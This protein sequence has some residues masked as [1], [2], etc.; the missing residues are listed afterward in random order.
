MLY[1]NTGHA[2][3]RALQAHSEPPSPGAIWIDLLN[4]TDEERSAA[5][6]L[7]GLRVP[8]QTELAEVE[9]S[10]CLATE[11][12]T[13]Y[14]SMS[15]A[16]RSAEGVPMTAPLG[17]VLS[18]DHL[19]TV[20]SAVLPAFE[21]FAERFMGGPREPCS[22][23][24]FLGL[25]EATVDRLADVLELVGADLDAISRRVFRPEHGGMPKRAQMDLQLR[26]TL[27]GVGNAG[28]RVS[29]IRDSL[30][31]VNRIV[32]YTDEVAGGWVPEDLRPRFKTL[33]RD[34]A[35]LSD[36]DIQLTDK[37]QFL[38]DAT[39]GFINIEQNNGIKI[40]TVVSIVGVPPTLI[41][42]IYGMNFKNIPELQW[43]HGYAYG[44][45]AIAL[46]AILPL[47]WFK[48]RGWI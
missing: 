41:A 27:R 9:S 14:L 21:Q 22:V 16:Y 15:M 43:E 28:E 19:M 26:A 4:P 12:R 5:E 18:P 42:S 37:V 1:I 39:L 29:N 8:A 45:T 40:L 36:Y 33:S 34:I 47:L 24:A 46:S 38:L 7:T 32:Q 13:L 10:S 20:R 17:F 25:L 30:L 48:R 31:G 6:R 35:S 2:P 11:G 3:R 44:L 23:S